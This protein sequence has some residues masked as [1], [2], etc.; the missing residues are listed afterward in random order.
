MPASYLTLERGTRVVDRFG[1]TVGF[2]RRVLIAEGSHFDGIVVDT[3][4]GRRFVDAL[5][6]DA[7]SVARSSSRSHV[8]TSNTP[9]RR[10]RRGRATSTAC[11]ATASR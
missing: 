5:K 4:A 1:Q 7:L 2:V 9:D 11:G 10:D 6:S 8:Q 3:S